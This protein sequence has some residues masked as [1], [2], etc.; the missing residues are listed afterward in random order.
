[1][2][3]KIVVPYESPMCVPLGFEVEVLCASYFG[4]PTPGKWDEL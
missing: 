2:E 3:R 4:I 1:M